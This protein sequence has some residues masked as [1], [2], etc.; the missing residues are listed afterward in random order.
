M[1][2]VVLTSVDTWLAGDSGGDGLGKVEGCLDTNSV[3]GAR[4]SPG[5]EGSQSAREVAEPEG[6]QGAEIGCGLTPTV[7]RGDVT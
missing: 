1:G 7:S 2:G 3:G 4:K 6:A 5:T